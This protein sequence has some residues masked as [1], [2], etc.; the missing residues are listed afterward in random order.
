MINMRNTSRNWP[1]C[2]TFGFYL[3][4][5]CCNSR[6]RVQKNFHWFQCWE[7]I[8]KDYRKQLRIIKRRSW[9]ISHSPLSHHKGFYPAY[10]LVLLVLFYATLAKNVSVQI[11]CMLNVWDMISMFRIVAMFVKHL[12]KNK[13]SQIMCRYVY[14][15]SPYKFHIPRSNVSLIIAIRPEAK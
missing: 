2:P 13:V 6:L 8:C 3:L 4:K 12:H 7:T 15:V 14:D 11:L 9:H 1:W 5:L 10:I